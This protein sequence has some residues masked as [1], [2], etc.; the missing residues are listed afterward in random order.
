[1]NPNP[2]F[3][4]GMQRQLQ[5]YM[6]GM[7]QQK[8]PY[9]VSYEALREKA[10]T[11][12]KPEAYGYVAAGAGSED[13]MAANLEAFRR[14]RIV[15]RILGDV[16]VCD[17]GVELLGRRL[18][19]PVMLAPIGVLGII[20]EGAEVAVAQAARET[21]LPFILST[22]SSKPMDEVAAAM[23]DVPHWF[24]L[25]WG[26]DPDF[27]AS[28]LSRAEAAG[29]SALVVTLD[30]KLLAWRDRDIQNAYLPF[31]YGDGLA[32]YFSDPV[33]RAALDEPP[34]QNPTQAI[35]HFA[36]VFA[37]PALTW[38]DLAF[39]RAHTRLPIL[40]KGILHPDDA[41]QAVDRG[42]DGLIVSNHGGRQLDGAVAALDALPG[43]VAA[44][45]GRVP[46]LFDSG[47]RRGADVFKAVA[48]GARAVLLGRPYVYGL[49]VGGAAGVREVLLNLMAEIDL[50]LA[51]SGCSSF[52]EV[53]PDNLVHG[54]AGEG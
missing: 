48:L 39:L 9:P 16:S 33:F 45:S 13:T 28:L 8:P 50:T 29:Y 42:V 35:L 46:V 17:L 36:N 32:N 53:G 22:V 24:Q 38:D 49:A 25:Y 5:I 43:V 40:L 3:S 21:G 11:L 4:L 26:R 1:V 31:L 52:A 7:M 47:I 54:P 41:R 44:V 20:H 18:P 23:G 19:V 10:R 6:A 2:P 12:L 37:N 51:L 14:W 34:E 30:T 27:T 15:P